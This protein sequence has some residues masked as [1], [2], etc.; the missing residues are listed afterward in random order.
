MPTNNRLAR[1]EQL[2]GFLKGCRA[3]L[4]PSQVGLTSAARRR[5]PGL[6]REDVAALAGVSIRWY[7]WLEQGRDINVSAEVLGR[8]SVSL[9]LSA[10]ERDYLFALVHGP[11][12]PYMSEHEEQITDILWKTIQFL[13]I[14]A[15]VMTLRWDIVAWNRLIAQTFRDY[16]AIPA[17]ERNLMRI[18]LTDEK[19]Q[20]DPAEFERM[21]TQLLAK[22]RVDFSQCGDDEHFEALIADFKANVPCFERLWA[23]AEIRGSLRG[24]NIIQHHQYGELRFEHSSYVPEDSSFQRVLMFIPANV[25]TAEVIASLSRGIPVDCG[26]NAGP[27]KTTGD[28]IYRH[29]YRH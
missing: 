12:T 13:P 14:P 22:F 26:E 17:L 23:G 15:L 18:I 1:R 27:R 5:S 25:H 7:T 9:R 4:E 8:I 24:S 28:A 10:E 6:R 29:P 11:R 19:Y 16:G 3:R 20:S 21:V 2:K